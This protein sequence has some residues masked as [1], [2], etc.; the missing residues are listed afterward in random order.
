[1]LKELM[2]YLKD[3]RQRLKWTQRDLSLESSISQTVISRIE[4]GHDTGSVR[5]FFALLETLDIDREEFIMQLDLI[6]PRKQLDDARKHKDFTKMKQVLEGIPSYIREK[7]SYLNTYCIYHE[8]LLS[9]RADDLV[10]AIHLL[11]EAKSMLEIYNPIDVILAEVHLMIGIIELQL[12]REAFQHF[13]KANHVIKNVLVT[14]QNFKHIIR[15]YGNL[16]AI[17]CR[18]GW[19]HLVKRELDNATALQKQFESTYLKTDIEYSRLLLYMNTKD[20]L[21]HDQ[22]TYMKCLLKD[23]PNE[24]IKQSL[25]NIRIRID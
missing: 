9:Y 2:F 1:M 4:N 25:S 19:F 5:E 13:K 21:L 7:N 11:Q 24:K 18:K 10:R 22:F 23:Y 3:K 6:S 8:A 15:V 20:P 17:Y 16:A 12:G 14:R